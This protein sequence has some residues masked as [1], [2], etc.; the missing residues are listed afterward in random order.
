MFKRLK[1]SLVIIPLI[2]VFFLAPQTASAEQTESSSTV[3]ACEVTEA[4]LN[5]G[6]LERW[7]S[8]ISGSIAHGSWDLDEVEYEIPEFVWRDGKG[9]VATD[10]D[11]ASIEFEGTVL[12]KGHE[13]L[14]Q[15]SVGNPVFEVDGDEGLLFLDLTST[16]PTGETDV[17]VTEELTAKFDLSDAVSIDDDLFQITAAPGALTDSGAAAFGGFYDG[18]EE[19]D[20][21]TL[22]AK[23]TDGCT[24]GEVVE[25]EASSSDPEVEEAEESS[26]EAQSTAS[27]SEESSMN[28]FETIP[29]ATWVAIG[30]AIVVVGATGGF[31][32]ARRRKD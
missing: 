16:T 15:V 28:D 24:F 10:A 25:G 3:E 7:R 26:T 30:V 18:D 22:T 29:T 2:G 19:T 31:F 1:K 17:A 9:F 27:E 6:T 21:I 11:T 13:D 14:L 32:L 5:W 4:Q 20:A 23:A 12:F 8:Y